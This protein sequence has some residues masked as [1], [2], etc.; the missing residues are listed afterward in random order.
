MKSILTN[1]YVALF[2]RLM[3]G[4]VFISASID[5]ISD[6]T[7]FAR[8]VTNYKLIGGTLSLLV[9]TIL[10]WVELLCAFFI[11][12]GLFLRGSTLLIILMLFGF[13]IVVISGIVRGLDISCGCFTLD[14]TVGKIGWQK[15]IENCGL[16]AASILLFYSESRTFIIKSA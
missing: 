10:P 1:E 13:T 4:L 11:L 3:L 6:P 14:P 5:K 16:I 15:V 7:A 2:L 8:A 12:S 9:A